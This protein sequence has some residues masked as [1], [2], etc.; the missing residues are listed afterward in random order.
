MFCQLSGCAHTFLFSML[1][2]IAEKIKP[3]GNNLV[4]CE[5]FGCSFM[6]MD[7]YNF[8]YDIFGAWKF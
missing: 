4:K 3:G 5:T 1:V 7:I 2:Y 6:N 8:V